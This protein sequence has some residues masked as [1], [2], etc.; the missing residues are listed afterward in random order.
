MELAE[1][2]PPVEADEV[3][4]AVVVNTLG[5]DEMRSEIGLEE[6]ETVDADD[7]YDPCAQDEFRQAVAGF[8][9]GSAEFAYLHNSVTLDKIRSAESF[10]LR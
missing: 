5:I 4:E 6:P 3:V 9:R 8:L 7:D 2:H 1:A 10:C